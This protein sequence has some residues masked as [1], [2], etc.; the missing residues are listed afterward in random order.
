MRLVSPLLD[1]AGTAP[2]MRIATTVF[3]NLLCYIGIG[4]PLAVIP[5]FVHRTLGFDAVVAGF[6][7]SLQY[8]ATFASRASAGRQVDT[9][10]P[11]HAVIAGLLVVSGAGLV[12]MLA[13]RCAAWPWAGLA[14]LLLSRGL[15]GFAESWTATG[16]ITWGIGQVGVARTA[17]VISMNGI[18]SYGGIA[19]GA[20]IGL[21]LA[22]KDG[23]LPL[24]ALTLVLGLAGAALASRRRPVPVSGGGVRLGFRHILL[25]VA[26]YGAA[27][28]LASVGFGVIA[29]FVTLFYDQQGW[30]GIGLAGPGTALSAFGASFVVTRVLF[31]RQI[32]LR[33]GIATAITSLAVET[34]GLLV[35]WQAPHPLAAIVGSALAGAGFALVFPALGVLAVARVAAQNRGSAISAFSVFLDI[36][37]GL[38]GPL[39]G[40]LASGHGYAS[41]FLAAAAASVAALLLCLW[42]RR[43]ALTS[44][45]PLG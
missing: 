4:L 14:L 7:V 35:L 13:A 3:F 34:V 23:L 28:A 20:P 16:C 38:S 45:T 9:G 2:T 29:A 8:L 6:A 31:A 24:G 27:L 26:P 44:P 11:K 25:T 40:L 18:T 30:H 42:L 21:A 1:R 22:G 19:L 10:G 41:L 15:L 39:L 33:G 12:L 43:A 37:L 32:G 5:T 36:S 17:Q